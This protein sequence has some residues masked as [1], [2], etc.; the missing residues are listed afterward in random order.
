M[1]IQHIITGLKY[2]TWLRMLELAFMRSYKMF[3]YLAKFNETPQDV[4]HHSCVMGGIASPVVNV[5]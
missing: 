3:S 2:I 5:I 4:F 1:Q